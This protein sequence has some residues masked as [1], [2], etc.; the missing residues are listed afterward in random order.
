MEK[1]NYSILLNLIIKKNEEIKLDEKNERSTVL[2]F[3]IWRNKY[4]K[5]YILG[6]IKLYFANRGWHTFTLDGL[7][8]NRNKDYFNK[9]I[10]RN[11][12][13][14][15]S[16]RPEIIKVYK[17]PQQLP[18]YSI[19]YLK[20]TT[21]VRDSVFVIYPGFIPPS[22]TCLE[23]DKFY[24]FP[25]C[26]GFIPNSVTDLTL[27][28]EFDQSI[29]IDDLPSSIR[30]LTFGSMFNK[31][32]KKGSIPNGVLSITFGSMFD[33]DIEVDVIPSSCVELTFGQKFNK[34][35][36]IGSIPIGVKTLKLSIHYT[37]IIEPNVLPHS[38]TNLNIG[39]SFY[40]NKIRKIEKNTIPTSCV[41][42]RYRGSQF[43]SIDQSTIPANVNLLKYDIFT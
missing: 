24:N 30:Y 13:A 16:S 32:L 33:Q 36:K 3:K 4:L 28:N 7:N 42:L 43:F 25:L 20:F 38:I 31:P 18:K 26:K 1:S 34:T 5:N 14:V 17:K 21:R 27:G 6:T 2:F 15:R 19:K 40:A 22:V 29:E 11:P 8:N 10:L 9:I 39:S 35:F 12:I 37:K 41:E 23:M